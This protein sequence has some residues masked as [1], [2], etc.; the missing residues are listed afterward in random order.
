MK[1]G[2]G[3]EQKKKTKKNREVVIKFDTISS[4]IFTHYVLKAN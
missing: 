1:G 3:D 4:A 2:G